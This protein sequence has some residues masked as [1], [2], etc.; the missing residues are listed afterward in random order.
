M[1]TFF[2]F[3]CIKMLKYTYEIIIPNINPE[4]RQGYIK[5][6]FKLEKKK[7]NPFAMPVNNCQYFSLGA[8]MKVQT[9]SQSNLFYY[10]FWTGSLMC[11]YLEL[12]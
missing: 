4:V 10:L 5:P 8:M 1:L 12:M 11:R 2:G 6:V 3:P 9:P 7:K